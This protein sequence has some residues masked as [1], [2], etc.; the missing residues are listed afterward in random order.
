MASGYNP[1]AVESSWYDWWEGEAR[2]FLCH[3]IS[4]TECYWESAH[5]SWLDGSH[6][7]CTG[8]MVRAPYLLCFSGC[9]IFSMSC[10]G[11][12]CREKQ[13]SGFQVTIML[14]YQLN[15]LW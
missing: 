12:A 9:S 10:E 6:S 11:I 3:G 4:A 5:W 8:K 15:L 7:G 1:I 13:L 2:R 14:G